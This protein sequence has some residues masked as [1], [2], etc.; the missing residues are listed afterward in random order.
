MRPTLVHAHLVATFPGVSPRELYDTY[1]DPV[2]HARATGQPAKIEARVGGRL[3]AYGGYIDG[4]FLRLVPGRTIIQFWRSKDFK[5]SDPDAILSIELKKDE[6]GSARMEL[7]FTNAPD[8][9]ESNDETGWS[10]AYVEAFRDHLSR[11]KRRRRA[12]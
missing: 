10:N 1:M 8:H 11:K 5:K 7:L 3:S 12:R 4:T 6:E 2:E 9:L